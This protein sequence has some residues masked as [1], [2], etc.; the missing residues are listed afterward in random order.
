MRTNHARAGSLYTPKGLRK[1]ITADERRRFLATAVAYRRLEI[2]TLCLTLAHT[3]CWISEAL[4]IVPTSIAAEEG[5][6]SVRSL[7]KRAGPS[8]TERFR[9]RPNSLQRWRS[10]ID[11]TPLIAKYAYGGFPGAARGNWS[12]ESCEK[13]AS[14]TAPMRRPRGCAMASGF[15]PFVPGCL[16]TWCNAGSAM[17]ASRRRPSTFRR[18]V[19]RSAKSRRGCGPHEPPG[20][21]C[22]EILSSSIRETTARIGPLR[23]LAFIARKSPVLL[24]DDRSS[25]GYRR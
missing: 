3:G 15:T 19:S 13:P 21:P 11:S 14:R 12:K 18:W 16:S 25:K 7:K 24:C 17:P 10:S 20:C 23:P 5:F 6:I 4:A 22:P 2:G 8:S 9:F 1:Y